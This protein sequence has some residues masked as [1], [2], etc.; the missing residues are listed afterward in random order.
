MHTVWI[1]MSRE[2]ERDSDEEEIESGNVKKN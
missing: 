2:I 1:T